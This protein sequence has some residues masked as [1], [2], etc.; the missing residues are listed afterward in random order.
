M[1]TS[2]LSHCQAQRHYSYFKKRAEPPPEE[3]W[4]SLFETPQ[5]WSAFPAFLHRQPQPQHS[6]QCTASHVLYASRSL[7]Q[8]PP[9]SCRIKRP[10]TCAIFGPNRWDFRGGNRKPKPTSP[11]FRHRF[12]YYALWCN[13]RGALASLH[14]ERLRTLDAAPSG[15]PKV[16]DLSQ[17]LSGTSHSCK[18]ELACAVVQC[19]AGTCSS[20]AA[21]AGPITQMFV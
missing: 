4:E 11:D 2:E 17:S 14:Q 20:Q 9:R 18:H 5:D 7:H 3:L 16:A 13:S 12:K 1:L 6:G 8:Q 21:P 10:D 19:L 15:T